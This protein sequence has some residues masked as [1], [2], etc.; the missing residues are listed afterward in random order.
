MH[1]RLDDN[2]GANYLLVQFL[3]SIRNNQHLGN[4]WLI[5]ATFL[6][7]VEYFSKVDGDLLRAYFLS[8]VSYLQHST[9]AIGEKLLAEQN[10]PLTNSN[11]DF[12]AFYAKEQ[13]ESLCAIDKLTKF[14]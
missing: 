7:N 8:P 14:F 12:V 11:A 2:H 3:I 13:I 9:R 4:F 5:F 10:S 6:T 1:F